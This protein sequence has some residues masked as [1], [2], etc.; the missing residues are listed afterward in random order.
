MARTRHAAHRHTVKE[1]ERKRR[2]RAEA[3]T[4]AW[5][6]KTIVAQLEATLEEAALERDILAVQRELLTEARRLKGRAS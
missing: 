5:F 4:L 2:R 3:K 1:R 6:P